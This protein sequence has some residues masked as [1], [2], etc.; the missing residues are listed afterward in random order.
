MTANEYRTNAERW[1]EAARNAWVSAD[2][3]QTLLN[4]ADSYDAL[5]KAAERL[6]RQ[7][8]IEVGQRPGRE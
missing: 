6:A 3:R 1:R 7:P 5:A 8:I 2:D 4:L